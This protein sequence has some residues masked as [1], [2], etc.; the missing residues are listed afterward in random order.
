M[1]LVLHFPVYNNHCGQKYVGETSYIN[2]CLLLLRSCWNK[3]YDVIVFTYWILGQQILI[4]DISNMWPFCFS[5]RGM[6]YAESKCAPSVFVFRA[7]RVVFMCLLLESRSKVQLNFY[8]HY[9]RWH[10]KIKRKMSQYGRYICLSLS[11]RQTV[12]SLLPLV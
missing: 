1:M 4:S 3:S 2:C 11:T 7:Q 6:G 10:S 8:L 12:A 9:G 5:A